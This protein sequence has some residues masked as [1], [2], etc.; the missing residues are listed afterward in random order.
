MDRPA[1]DALER[2]FTGKPAE[3]ALCLG[4][5]GWVCGLFPET[6]VRVQ[7]SQVSLDHVHP[8][9]AAWLP[10]R[11]VKGRPAHYLVLSF[12]LGRHLNTDRVVSAVEPH[13]GRW[14]HHV[15][16]QDEAELDPELAAWLGED[17]AFAAARRRTGQ[18]RMA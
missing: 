6:S 10:V 7:K 15:L 9:A 17:Y 1:A 3:H 18:S 11:S 12:G 8:Y 13:P 5:I 16:L 4:L 14:T 2:Y